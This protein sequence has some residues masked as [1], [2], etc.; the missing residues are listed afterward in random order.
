MSTQDKPLAGLVA[1]VTGASRGIGR[2]CAIGL[3]GAGAHVI[4]T[5]R[6]Q[7]ALESLDDEIF[8][9]T[10]EHATLVPLDLKNGDGVDQLG[11]AIYGRWKKLDILVHAAGELGILTPVAHID[12][13]VW[14]HTLAVNMTAT[15]RLI[16]SMD[17]LL[18]QSAAGR[19]I[20]FTTGA[21]R[22]PQAFW[23]AY[24]ATKA[25]MEALVESY[26]DETAITPLRI[27]LL[28]PG[29]MRTNMRA[30]AFPG[31]DPMT[32]PAPEEIVPLVLDLVRADKEPPA[33]VVRFVREKA[34]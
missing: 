26:R 17:A 10:G 9:L 18:R 25:G 2:A 28:S 33:G 3:A 34:V 21:A 7:G 20:F 24:A 13:T 4:A 31:E 15:F 29:P 23:G 11:A 30:S 32:L 12:P 5:G 1:L 22:N 6:V 16:R 19:A 27:A 8:K 14:E